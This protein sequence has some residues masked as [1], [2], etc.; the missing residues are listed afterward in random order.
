EDDKQVGYLTVWKEDITPELIKENWR[1]LEEK[2][3]S[4]VLGMNFSGNRKLTCNLTT[5][6]YYIENEE[7]F[8]IR[9]DIDIDAIIRRSKG[10]DYSY[11]YAELPALQCNMTINI[12]PSS[13]PATMPNIPP[14]LKRFILTV[15]Q[16]EDLDEHSANYQDEKLKRWFLILEELE[17]TKNT[18]SYNE[19][20]CARHFV[21]H[22]SC[23]GSEVI[24]FLKRELPSAVYVNDSGKEEARFSRDNQ[25]HISLVSQYETKARNWARNLI[26]QQITRID[27]CAT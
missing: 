12:Q 4:F 2:V 16:A 1:S 17:E 10:E 20:K 24:L 11:C 21:S 3:E 6:N 27:N 8:H 22:S 14:I 23:H 26:N 13:L 15:I 19:I 25:S 9:N 5:V 7:P 18:P